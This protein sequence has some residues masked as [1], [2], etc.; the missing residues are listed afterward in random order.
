MSGTA[1]IIAYGFGA[2]STVAK[3]PT[4]GFGSASVTTYPGIEM[5]D[6]EKPLHVSDS[7]WLLH[8]SDEGDRI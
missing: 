8:I 4:L 6:T 3:V 2:W 5:S 7:D 1:D